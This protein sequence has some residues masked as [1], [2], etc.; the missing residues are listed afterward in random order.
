MIVSGETNEIVDSDMS[1]NDDL[2]AD[3]NNPT[4]PKLAAKTIHAAGELI[5]NPNDPRRTRSQFESAMCMKDLM[6]DEK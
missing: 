3:P 5:G 1:D 6:F 2:I 4:R